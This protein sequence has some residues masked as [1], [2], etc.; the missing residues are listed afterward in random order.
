MSQ[1]RWNPTVSVVRFC[2]LPLCIFSPH[3]AAT[4]VSDPSSIYSIFVFYNFITTDILFLTD[5]HSEVITILSFVSPL[6][7]HLHF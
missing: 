6:D 2:S 5:N 1:V 7:L 4:R 3:R